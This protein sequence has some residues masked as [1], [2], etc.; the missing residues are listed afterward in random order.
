MSLRRYY[1]NK[2]ALLIIVEITILNG[3]NAHFKR[4]LTF[5]MDNENLLKVR[6][7]LNGKENTLTMVHQESSTILMPTF[8]TSRYFFLEKMG[9]TSSTEVPHCALLQQVSIG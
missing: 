9:Q 4:Q 3:Q 1:P 6:I 2:Y 5:L 8:L 7:E